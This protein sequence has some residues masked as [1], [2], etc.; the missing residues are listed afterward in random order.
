[1]SPLFIFK[2]SVYLLYR[3]WYCAKVVENKYG[4]LILVKRSGNEVMLITYGIHIH[5]H[6]LILIYK[7]KSLSTRYYD[8][9]SMTVP[10]I[11]CIEY[12]IS[13]LLRPYYILLQKCISM[14]TMFREGIPYCP[15]LLLMK[16]VILWIISTFLES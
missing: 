1:M 5:T 7:I 4:L 11:F 3:R 14:H 8:N 15:L 10:R 6:A 2:T 9:I 12:Q 13:E 16:I